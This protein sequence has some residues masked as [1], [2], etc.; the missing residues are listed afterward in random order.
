MERIQEL[1]NLLNTETLSEIK[2]MSVKDMCEYFK[3]LK[4]VQR[5]IEH[6]QKH[7]DVGHLIILVIKIHESTID[8]LS[9]KQIFNISRKLILIFELINEHDLNVNSI[10]AA[11]LSVMKEN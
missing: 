10:V 3:E 1:K 7:E 2:G 11:K 9:N 6:N 8:G 5:R 4:E